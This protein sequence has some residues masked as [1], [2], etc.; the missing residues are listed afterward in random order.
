MLGNSIPSRSL[1]EK[2]GKTEL[3]LLI[4]CP[5]L[6]ILTVMNLEVSA[7]KAQLLLSINTDYMENN[8][9]EP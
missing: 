3:L 4:P 7:P 6:V 2:K 1:L 5:W 8:S 9:E